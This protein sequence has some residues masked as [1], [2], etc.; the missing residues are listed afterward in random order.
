MR[1]DILQVNEL[2][3]DLVEKYI[4]NGESLPALERIIQSMKKTKS[5]KEYNK[6][7]PWIQWPSF[8]TGK[9]FENHKIYRLGDFDKY[10]GENILKYW[11][12][13]GREVVCISPMNL[14]NSLKQKGIFL[15]DP[16][17]NTFFTGPWALRWVYGAIKSFVN[18]NSSGKVSKFSYT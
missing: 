1:L 15:P 10:S 8:Y 14:T 5:E 11:V 9:S 12:D 18:N 17:T 13:I 4:A 16:W 6:L 7:E 2:N 3:F